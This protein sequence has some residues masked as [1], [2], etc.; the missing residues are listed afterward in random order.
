M[1]RHD[2]SLWLL[3]DKIE[4][5]VNSGSVNAD[6]FQPL[7]GGGGVDQPICGIQRCPPVAV[8]VPTHADPEAREEPL[9]WRNGSPRRTTYKWSRTKGPE[10][11]SRKDKGNQNSHMTEAVSKEL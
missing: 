1:S 11:A 8:L 7:M 10:L 9:E 5:A 3:A 2:D 6:E 4:K